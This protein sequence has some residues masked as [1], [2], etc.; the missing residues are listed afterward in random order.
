MATLTVGRLPIRLSPFVG[1][2]CELQDVVAALARSRLLTLTGPGGT[3]KTRLALA[4]AQAVAADYAG[5]VCWAELAAVSDP[6]IVSR[7][8]ADGLGVPDDPGLDMVDGIAA[9][10]GDQRVLLVLDNCEHLTATV[11]GLCGQLLGTCPGLTILATSR[12][13]LGVDGE[14]SWPVPPLSLPE[15]SASP[16]V[17]VLAAS[18]AV[19]FFEQRGQLVA[20]S[21]R[22]D[23]DNAAAVLHVVR[24]LDG[25]PLAIDLAAAQLRVLSAGQLAGRLD[26]MFALLIGG[27]RTAPPRHQ[28]LRATLD[29]SHHLL[30]DDE[31]AVFRRL[32]VFPV[33]FT[34][35]A[36]ERVTAGPG[37]DPG[38]TLELLTRLADKSLL[39]VAHSSRGARYRLL[40]TVREYALERLAE[41][42][43]QDA[44]RQA[45]LDFCADFVTE[46]AGRIDQAG[47]DAQSLDRELGRIDAE[48][49][50]LRAAMDFARQRGEAIPALRIA[51]RLGRFAYLRGHYQEVRQ[52]MDAAV[53]A[54]PGAPAALRAEA[55]LGSGRLALLQCDYPPA[56]RRLDAALRL[57]RELGDSRGVAS[58]LQVLGSVAREQGRYARSTE[59]HEES[60]AL[61]TAAGDQ[62]AAASAHGYL[63]F[64]SWLQ[65]DFGRATA[66]TTVALRMSRELGDVEGT[67]WSLI[68]LGTV[69]RYQGAADRAATL[70]Q[71][72]RSLAE[73]IGFREGIAWSLEQLGLLA[74]ERDDPGAV[75]LLR[76]SL[77]I[78]HELRDRWRAC[79][80]LDDLA[81]F[82]LAGGD[83]EQAARL[84]AAAAATREVI[85]TVVAPCEM[86]RHET[87][88]AGARAALGGGAF[89]TA[90]E[91]GRL[92]QIDTLVAGLPTAGAGTAPA[93]AAAGPV[94][95]T[96]GPADPA[97]A[98]AAGRRAARGGRPGTAG[99]L[100]I[101]ALGGASVYRGDVPLT[102]ADWGYAKPRELLFL[103]AT[104]APLTK[105]QVGAA[106]W[107]EQSPDQLANALHTALRGLRRAVG[108]PAWVLYSDGRY[109]FNTALPH[110]CDVTE[111]EQALAAARRAR[112]A[113]AAL[114][115]LE[116]AIAA[117]GG[118]FLDGL[119]AGDW[120]QTRRGELARSFESA[121]LAAGRL[122]AAARR[123]QAAAA[124]F[125]R[126][127]AHEPLNESA[128]RELMT[129]WA[130]M[131]QPARAV[132][133]YE[134]LVTLLREQVGVPPADETTALYRQLTSKA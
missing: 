128:H 130:R 95:A 39:R 35:P 90:W 131:G 13:L 5:L 38:R 24:R 126:A 73:K 103:L 67:A 23:E 133:H 14:R 56:I 96:A 119:A 72:S 58:A 114:P 64:V 83:A 40:S 82:T 41:A 111:F 6:G 1:R 121:L 16:A 46:A 53:T 43:E 110:E 93:G 48:L 9:H 17:S 84:L 125:R 87:T 28:T 120:A 10:I 25:L 66:E 134:E 92:A 78:H 4:A 8:I 12:E 107:P 117:Y 112:P 7:V 36:A 69:A 123:F 50:N 3:G 74:A 57:Y 76:D 101:R 86:A 97:G 80:V 62:R 34:L 75:T 104:S 100:R 11:A 132:A 26:D 124:A 63:G 31:R 2:R 91:Q 27:A 18:D 45:Q 68:S 60:L 127:V 30:D 81:A 20:P 70:L 105:Q 94:P 122:H 71:E 44:A 47:Q 55:L 61:A 33:G 52:W 85:G 89:E 65:G 98:A 118:E 129:C 37:I 113:A 106:L 79:S 21:F 54:D 99:L 42:G 77:L 15:D 115:D 49:P 102:A 51:G 109:R 32:G 116:R 108:D 59:L 19:A 88:M 29:W 22:L